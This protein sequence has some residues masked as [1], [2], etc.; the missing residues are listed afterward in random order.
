[1]AHRRAPLPLLRRVRIAPG[2]AAS[3]RCASAR[4]RRP[5]KSPAC[6]SA[7]SGP[8]RSRRSSSSG[9]YCSSGSRTGP[10]DRARR[11]LSTA[12]VFGLV[13]L[14]FRRK[15]PN[16]KW[17]LMAGVLGWFCGRARNQA[18]SIRAGMVTHALVFATWRGLLQL[19]VQSYLYGK[20]WISWTRTHGLSDGPQSAARRARRGRLV[21]HRREGPETGRR[22]KGDVLRNA[23][24]RSPKMPTASSC[25]S[26]TRPCRGRSS[27]ARTASSKARGR[28]PWSPT[29]APSAPARA[30]A[31]ARR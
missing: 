13:H 27:W 1:M 11:W 31:S 22:G 7:S 10:G 14:W 30:G 21:A 24:T 4:R 15:F 9:A 23:A 20:T 19:G 6:S 28:E 8:S 18:G 26:A 2:P 16:W 29:P 3:A 5:G 25:A 17:V 12:L